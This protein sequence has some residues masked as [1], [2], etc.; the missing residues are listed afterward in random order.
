MS[1]SPPPRR[2]RSLLLVALVLGSVYVG[3]AGTGS[4][5]STSVTV[6]TGTAVEQVGDVATF[7]VEL[8]GSNQARVQVGTEA[9]NYRVNLTIRGKQG[10]RVTIHM[11]TYEA[12]GWRGASAEE[13]FSVPNAT[14]VSATRETPTLEA[15]VDTGTYRVFT[16]VDG[17]L[18][19][20]GVL[21][22]EER[23]TRGLT[24]YTAPRGTSTGS[25]EAVM[26]NATALSTNAS[27]TAAVARGD[28]LVARVDATGL[29]G[30]VRTVDD[31]QQATDGVRLSVSTERF[32]QGRR[33]VDIQS[34]RLFTADE[35]LYLVLDTDDFDAEPGDSFRTQFTVDGS[36]NPYVAAGETE[37]RTR[38]VTVKKRR[39]GVGGDPLVVEAAGGQRVDIGTTLAPGTRLNV[40][41]VS[42]SVDNLFVKRQTVTVSEAGTASATFDFGDVT[43][44]TAFEIRFGGEGVSH[45]AYVGG[46]PN[47]TPTPTPTPEPTPTTA[48][49]T[50]TVAPTSTPTAEPTPTTVGTVDAAA[51]TDANS[52]TANESSGGLLAP[53]SDLRERA[54][55]VPL[56][57]LEIGGGTLLLLLAGLARRLL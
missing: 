11:N 55:D 45:T 14:L 51:T 19:D 44:R 13:V 41:A 1:P 38:T 39:I 3:G 32:N 24:L 30:Y 31:V 23:E 40:R 43:G 5:G 28:Y 54:P 47:A 17:G 48:E 49:P 37:R 16:R 25:L 53:V 33:F 42:R 34:G 9:V 29:S 56:G 18:T 6:G 57:P 35:R 36:K 46:D 50:P 20:I 10:E 15:P 26:A 22:L 52:S 21:E 8:D 27:E 2:F 12:G 7:T 4:T